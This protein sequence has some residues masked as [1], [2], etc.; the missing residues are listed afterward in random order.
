M[1]TACYHNLFRSKEYAADYEKK[2]VEMN[3]AQEETSFSFQKK[4]VLYNHNGDL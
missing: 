4:K 3:K 1:L 2:R